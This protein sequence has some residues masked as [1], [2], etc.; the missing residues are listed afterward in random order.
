MITYR[1]RFK[2]LTINGVKLG[3]TGFSPLYKWPNGTRLTTFGY[4]QMR[5]SNENEQYL[6]KLIS[7]TW[8]DI[9]RI[10]W[11]DHYNA[12]ERTPT[13]FEIPEMLYAPAK[14][15]KLKDL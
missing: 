5:V 11:Y 10:N 1:N 8:H 6:E 14:P 4:Y 15:Y 3:K 13:A 2:D 12:R 9:G 7:S